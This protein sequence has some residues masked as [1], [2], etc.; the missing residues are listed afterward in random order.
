MG[1]IASVVDQWT[2]ETHFASFPEIGFMNNH[3]VASLG[4][5][6]F[7]R[8]RREEEGTKKE[9]E[10]KQREQTKGKSNR[11]AIDYAR[12]KSKVASFLRSSKTT[13]KYG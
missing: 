9:E 5:H 7:S 3:R 10:K 12:I 11:S 8:E 1:L 2:S 4:D 6:L 13:F